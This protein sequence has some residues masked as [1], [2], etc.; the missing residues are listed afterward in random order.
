[1]KCRPPLVGGRATVHPSRR[2]VTAVRR[3]RSP[4]GARWVRGRRSSAVRTLPGRCP[5]SGCLPGA[6]APP[7]RRPSA[8]AAAAK[9]DGHVF[10]GPR[11]RSSCFLGRR[12]RLLLRRLEAGRVEDVPVALAVGWVSPLSAPP[13]RS[14]RPPGTSSCRFTGAVV[15]F[16]CTGEWVIHG[17]TAGFISH[18]I[19]TTPI[20]LTAENSELE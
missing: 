14:S 13:H 6:W 17:S 7:A 1:M 12:R 5:G 4:V 19:S 2:A 16:L 18:L 11:S 8:V 3:L 15:A 9:R 10:R 20:W